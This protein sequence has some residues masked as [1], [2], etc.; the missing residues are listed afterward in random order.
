MALWRM[1]RLPDGRLELLYTDDTMIDATCGTCTAAT[2]V[3]LLREWW[4]AEAASFDVLVDAHY[5]KLPGS[6]R[7]SN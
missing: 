1:E 3:G 2:P 4:L 6:S 7:M 5:V